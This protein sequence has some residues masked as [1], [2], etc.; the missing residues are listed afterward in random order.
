VI[1]HAPGWQVP[2]IAALIFSYHLKLSDQ[3]NAGNADNP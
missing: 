2:V 1:S 3:P